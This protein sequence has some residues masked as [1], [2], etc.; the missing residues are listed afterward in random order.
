MCNKSYEECLST[1]FDRIQGRQ[2]IELDLLPKETAELL[3]TEFMAQLGSRSTRFIKRQ[4]MFNN[5]LRDIY[6]WT[7]PFYGADGQLR[8]LLGGWTDIGQR[9]RQA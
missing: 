6:Q 3:H 8:G 5:G 1:R 4:L 2:L 7:V 9:I